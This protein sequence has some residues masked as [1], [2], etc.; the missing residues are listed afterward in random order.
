MAATL[1]CLEDAAADLS[2]WLPRSRCHFWM[3]HP[4]GGRLCVSHTQVD[5][6]GGL[7]WLQRWLGARPADSTIIDAPP[8][9]DNAHTQFHQWP[10]DLPEALPQN[11]SRPTH[12]QK[13]CQRLISVANLWEERVGI[14]VAIQSPHHREKTLW[15][16]H[17]VMVSLPGEV[18]H[19]WAQ[20]P[21]AQWRR[22]LYRAAAAAA[23]TTPAATRIRWVISSLG[24]LSRLAWLQGLGTDPLWLWSTPA[25]PG[26]RHLIAWGTTHWQRVVLSHDDQF[27]EETR[28]AFDLRCLQTLE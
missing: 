5:A 11:D 13:L 14:C 16:N 12:T 20:L 27:P 28:D 23:R 19:R 4:E 25:L 6:Y 24:D 26:S 2:Q 3:R 21:P 18:L 9:S 10:R 22:L 8:P 17:M 1:P 15:D 7:L